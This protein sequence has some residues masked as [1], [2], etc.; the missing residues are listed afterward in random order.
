MNQNI[1]VGFLPCDNGRSCDL[2]LIGCG[3][4]LVVNLDDHGV[5]IQLHLRMMAQHKLARYNINED[6][7][8]GCPVC[9]VA[10]EVLTVGNAYWYS[11]HVRP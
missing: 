1:L 6:G 10:R 5:G 2:H 3:N 8:D 11:L 9:F 4:F 7:T